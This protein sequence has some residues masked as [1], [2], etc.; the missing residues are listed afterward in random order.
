MVSNVCWSLVQMEIPPPR[1]IELAHSFIYELGTRGA[2]WFRPR[3]LIFWTASDLSTV[4]EWRSKHLMNASST[5]QG[6][7]AAMIERNAVSGSR[8][9]LA[10]RI[11]IKVNRERENSKLIYDANCPENPACCWFNGFFRRAGEIN[12]RIESQ[13]ETRRENILMWND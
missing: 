4:A 8:G 5:H 1:L 2:R 7:C 13:H 3:L 10:Q 12:T 9:K 11:S 6:R